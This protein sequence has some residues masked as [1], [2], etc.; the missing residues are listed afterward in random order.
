MVFG[1]GRLDPVTDVARQDQLWPCQGNSGRGF[2]LAGSANRAKCPGLSSHA[3]QP[4]RRSVLGAAARASAQ[5][6]MK[7]YPG[8][9]RLRI[10]SQQACGPLSIALSMRIATSLL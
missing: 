7:R 3:T 4:L 6:A 10:V 9:S 5:S 8:I 1:F 2:S